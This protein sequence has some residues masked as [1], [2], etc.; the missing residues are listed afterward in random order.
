MKKIESTVWRTLYIL[1][2]FCGL[3]VS[4]MAYNQITTTKSERPLDPID[5]VSTKQTEQ[6]MRYHGTDALMITEEKVYIWRDS[7]WIPVLE[8]GQG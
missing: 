3:W 7:E 8:R 5:W 1:I 6:L 4:Q 2:F